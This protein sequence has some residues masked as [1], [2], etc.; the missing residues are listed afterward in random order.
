MGISVDPVEHIMKV[1][2][3]GTSFAYV[4]SLSSNGQDR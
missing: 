4:W 3:L 2:E 1:L